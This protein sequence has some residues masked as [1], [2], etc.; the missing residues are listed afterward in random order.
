MNTPV[1]DNYCWLRENWKS[2]ITGHFWRFFLQRCWRA[3]GKNQEKKWHFFRQNSPIRLS[4]VFWKWYS[5]STTIAFLVFRISAL[6]VKNPVHVVRFGK[7]VWLDLIL[8]E[9]SEH[10]GAI[11]DSDG[12]GHTLQRAVNGILLSQ[13][14]CGGYTI[15]ILSAETAKTASRIV[16]FRL[17]M[18]TV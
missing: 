11:K 18:L 5:P 6:Q 1:S 4:A 12:Q 8:I 16:M 10:L 13:D 14:S 15:A 17:I 2:D 3:P 7:L 9:G